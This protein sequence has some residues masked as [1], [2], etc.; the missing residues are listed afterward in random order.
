MRRNTRTTEMTELMETTELMG[1]RRRRRAGQQPGELL[2]EST[3]F[4]TVW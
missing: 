1:L 3:F 4:I 2:P